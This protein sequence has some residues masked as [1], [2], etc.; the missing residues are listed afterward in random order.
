MSRLAKILLIIT[1]IFIFVGLLVGVYFLVKSKS[2]SATAI[3][4]ITPK[5]NSANQDPNGPYFHKIYLAASK[6]GLTWEKQEKVLFDHASVPGA[7]IKDGVIYLYFVDAS[8]DAGDQPSVG[9]SKDLG[10]TFQKQT[11]KIKGADSPAVDPDP[12]LLD[13]G[14]IRLY[15]FV[16]PTDVG[17]PAAA[18]GPHKIM[19]AESS[20]G[21][22]F[23]NVSEVFAEENIT[24]PD[25]FKTAK[26]WRLFISKGTDLDLAVSNDNGATFQRQNDF[27]WNNGGVSGTAD[28]SGT[29]RTYYCGQGGIDSATG[30]ETGKLTAESGVR[31]AES[32]KIVCDPSVIE[33]PDKTFLMFY[34]IA[35]FTQNNNI[36]KN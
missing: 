26:D 29:L 30:A 33:L 6:D 11:I 4:D 18:S 32:G 1:G 8:D 25:V 2:S 34:K 28:I 31:V 19:S 14:R 13:S 24:D 15:Y 7:V 16:S 21:I 5:S 9:I 35:E 10:Q 12:V 27:S 17:D 36:N 22:N 23:E 20:D 3:P